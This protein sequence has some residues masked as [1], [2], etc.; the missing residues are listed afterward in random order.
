MRL[1]CQNQYNNSN[2]IKNKEE[3]RKKNKIIKGDSNLLK[4]EKM[5]NRRK[6]SINKGIIKVNKG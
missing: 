2:R 6:N 1:T 3:G 5:C 4:Y